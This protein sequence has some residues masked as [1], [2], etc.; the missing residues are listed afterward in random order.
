MI[1]YHYNKAYERYIR[2]NRKTGA[3]SRGGVWEQGRHTWGRMACVVGKWDASPYDEVRYAIRPGYYPKPPKVGDT[4]FV[5]SGSKIP[6]DLLRNSGYKITRNKD[7][8]DY[9]VVSIPENQYPTSCCICGMNDSESFFIIHITDAVNGE[10]FAPSDQ[11]M[12]NIISFLNNDVGITQITTSTKGLKVYFIRDNQEHEEILNKSQKKYCLDSDI[13]LT[14]STTIS[15]ENLNIIWNLSDYQAKFKIL[16]GSDFHKYPYTI[17]LFLKNEMGVDYG[18]KYGESVNWF[19]KTI[20]YDEFENSKYSKLITPEDFD[21]L[22]NWILYQ[23]NMTD[24][25]LV[26]IDKLDRNLLYD[27]KQFLAYKYAVRKLSIDHPMKEDNL[28]ALIKN[29]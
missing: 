10:D 23:L 14:P 1:I 19:M 13:Q 7:Q 28:K 27:Y 15:P 24:S 18:F 6:R 5:S 11:E 26:K 4:L 22:Q 17:C 21:M 20:G 9:I 12:D 3:I 2:Y 16:M 25:G 29:T 8:A